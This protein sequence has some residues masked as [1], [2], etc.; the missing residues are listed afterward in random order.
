MTPQI[1]VFNDNDESIIFLKCLIL[2][3]V[4][5]FKKILHYIKKNQARHTQEYVKKNGSFFDNL[6]KMKETISFHHNIKE[7]N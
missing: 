1:L 2:K 3:F 4:I 6:Y 5:I 7:N